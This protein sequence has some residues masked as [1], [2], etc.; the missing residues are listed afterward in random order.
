MKKVFFP[1]LI[2]VA[3]AA[4][5]QPTNTSSGGKSKVSAPFAGS[6]VSCGRNDSPDLCSRYLLLQRG[7]RICGTWSYVASYKSYDGRVVAEAVSSVEARR[8]RICGRPGSETRTE[9]EDGWETIDRPLH[10]CDEKLGDLDG[11]GGRCYAGFVRVKRPDPSLEELAAEPW[12]QACLSD[13]EEVPAQQ[14]N[15]THDEAAWLKE[16]YGAPIPNVA[17][18]RADTSSIVASRLPIG[19]S[20]GR[21]L[22]FLR[23]L[24]E[25]NVDESASD[26]VYSTHRGEGIKGNRRDIL[27]KLH[28]GPDQNIKSISSYI[29][30]SNNI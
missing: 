22:E 11:K 17:T 7:K 15:P 14:T 2:A 18:Q 21:A 16:I 28:L 9:C 4:G 19:T 30:K 29:D 27:I 13:Q 12:V 24:G 25:G 5:A 3:M 23:G 6:W 8:T 26:I 10:L 1:M 20:R